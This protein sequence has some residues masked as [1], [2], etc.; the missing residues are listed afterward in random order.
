MLA[1]PRSTSANARSLAPFAIRERA[2][3]NDSF[4]SFVHRFMAVLAVAADSDPCADTARK[5]EAFQVFAHTPSDL[6]SHVIFEG[7]FRNEQSQSRAITQKTENHTQ[8]Y[9]STA[10]AAQG[11]FE[12]TSKKE[13][14]TPT[15]MMFHGCFKRASEI[16]RKNGVLH[17]LPRTLTSR[18]RPQGASRPA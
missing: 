8:K 10:G 18:P 5:Q 13:L 12:A 4:L 6:P 17:S 16:S 11:N 14:Q 15:T 2:A 7:A 1:Q 3:R 9:D